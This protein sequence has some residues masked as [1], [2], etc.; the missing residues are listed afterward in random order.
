MLDFSKRCMSKIYEMSN[1]ELFNLN[2]DE[3]VARAAN[4][5][6]AILSSNCAAVF[7]ER[8]RRMEA[9]YVRYYSVQR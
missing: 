6:E 7:N 1:Y 4:A 2:V 8:R 3:L 5:D 9:A